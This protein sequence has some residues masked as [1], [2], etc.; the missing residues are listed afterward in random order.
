MTSGQRSPDLPVEGNLDGS[1]NGVHGSQYKGSL[2]LAACVPL[3][4]WVAWDPCVPLGTGLL[5][6]FELNSYLL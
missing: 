2:L 3:G 6:T 4:T 1:G 5:V